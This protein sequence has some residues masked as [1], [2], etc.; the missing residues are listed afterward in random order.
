MSR[1]IRKSSKRLVG[2]KPVFIKTVTDGA[3]SFRWAVRYLRVLASCRQDNSADPLQALLFL[4]GTSHIPPEGKMR[5]WA[6]HTPDAGSAP[7]LFRFL[8]TAKPISSLE[9]AELTEPSITLL[10]SEINC[11]PVLS[12]PPAFLAKQPWRK[13]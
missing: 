10:P 11:P 9:G 2:L 13:S 4:A 8:D 3:S 12:F 7:P 6:S 5:F 1:R